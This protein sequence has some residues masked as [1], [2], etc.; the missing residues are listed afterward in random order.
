MRE[1]IKIQSLFHESKGIAKVKEVQGKSMKEL[2][3]R[4]RDEK[5]N[6]F[7]WKLY[8]QDFLD[9]V[10]EK[11]RERKKIKRELHL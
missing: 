8:L 11:E 7:R 1:I 10:K 4:E 3:A 6:C 9:E 5:K 2:F